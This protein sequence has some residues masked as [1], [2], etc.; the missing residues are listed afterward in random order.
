MLKI[1]VKDTGT[2]ID[3]NI[4]NKLGK[5]FQTFDNE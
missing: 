1:S 2:G 4:M 3:P 5:I